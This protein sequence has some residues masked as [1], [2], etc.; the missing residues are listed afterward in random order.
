MI[1][2]YGIITG[3]ILSLPFGPVGIYCM[4]KAV[5]KGEKKAYI[6]AIGMVTVDIIYGIVSYLFF[7]KIAKYIDE[8][9]FPLTVLVS[10]FLVYAGAK[11]FF[12]KP[13]LKELETTNF[14][15]LQDYF[16]TFLLAV[17]NIGSIPVIGAIFTFLKVTTLPINDINIIELATGIGLGGAS[18]WAFTIYLIHHFKKKV[19]VDVLVRIS[20]YSGLLILILAMGSICTMAYKY[21][22]V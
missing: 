5:I 11:K 10:L 13:E 15:L 12:C 2:L 18:L 7:S 8:Y 22:F 6:S 21:F 9:Q 17:F 20:K 16:E 1:F 19:T 4:E 14:T 3:F